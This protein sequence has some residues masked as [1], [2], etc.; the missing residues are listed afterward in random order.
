MSRSGSASVSSQH[1]RS[2]LA[3]EK[4]EGLS[5]QPGFHLSLRRSSPKFYLHPL[6]SAATARSYSKAAAGKY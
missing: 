2:L 4:K 5:A 6:V 3:V 1:Y